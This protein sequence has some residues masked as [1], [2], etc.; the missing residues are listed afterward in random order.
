MK[1]LISI[2]LAVIMITALVACSTSKEKEK[3]VF[4]KMKESPVAVMES[5]DGTKVYV[6]NTGNIAS[7][8]SLAIEET[9]L[10]P[11]DKERDWLYRITY[12][13]KDKLVGGEEIIVSF[14]NDYI[15]IGSEFYLPKQDVNYDGILEWAE[16]KF[17]YLVKEYGAE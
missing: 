5:S 4:D 7:L 9:S 15:Q 12:N 11:A 13:P 2:F 10:E 14:H 8:A 1:K 3:S 6:W 16:M 17:E